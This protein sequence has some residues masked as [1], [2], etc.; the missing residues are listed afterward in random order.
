MALWVKHRIYVGRVVSIC[1]CQLPK[2]IYKLPALHTRL[3]TMRSRPSH[4]NK[5]RSI[6]HVPA[7]IGQDAELDHE[8][9]MYLTTATPRAELTASFLFNSAETLPR[10][11]WL[12]TDVHSFHFEAPPAPGRPE[13]GRT[14]TCTLFGIRLKLHGVAP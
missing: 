6:I 14:S 9:Y 7:A 4:S 10:L 8:L 3:G 11:G 12:T 1:L 5:P 13:L 2:Q